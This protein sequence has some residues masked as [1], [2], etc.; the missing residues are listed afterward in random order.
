MRFQNQLRSLGH[1]PLYYYWLRNSPRGAQISSAS[2][3]K[4]EI[5]ERLSESKKLSLNL[6]SL[7][8]VKV[9]AKQRY[10]AQNETITGCI[11]FLLISE[12]IS[13]YQTE[14]NFQ[15]PWNVF[16]SGSL[17]CIFRERKPFGS[18]VMLLFRTV[19]IETTLFV[20]CVVWWRCAASRD[21]PICHQ[22]RFY[23]GELMYG[24]QKSYE[25]R[26]VLGRPIVI[27]DPS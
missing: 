21:L 15:A 16:T 3:R 1:T 22:I 12:L 23:K 25:E 18:D 27:S 11:L 2:R 10:L 13:R 20:R 9:R 8:F 6:C 19:D 7:G 14:R 17:L 26:N 4:F 24:L 5:T